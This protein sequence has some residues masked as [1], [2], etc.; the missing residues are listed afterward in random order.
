M[1]AAPVLAGILWMLGTEA[2]VAENAPPPLELTAEQDHKL[3]LDQLGITSI[4]PGANGRDAN[5]PN[6]ANYDE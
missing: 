4:R 5:A 2:A 6:A 1:R 3:M